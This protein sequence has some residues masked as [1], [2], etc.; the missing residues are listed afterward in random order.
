[1]NITYFIYVKIIQISRK[2]YT[3]FYRTFSI[4]IIFEK[5]GENADNVYHS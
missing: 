2:N 5:W 1:M 3:C 4:A